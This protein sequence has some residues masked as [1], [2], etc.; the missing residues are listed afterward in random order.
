MLPH[1]LCRTFG[2]HGV[3]FLHFPVST[4]ARARLKTLPLTP[5]SV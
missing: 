1:R 5:T 3:I 2:D 4:E